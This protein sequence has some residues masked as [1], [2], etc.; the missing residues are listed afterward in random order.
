VPGIAT[1]PAFRCEQLMHYA[2]ANLLQRTVACGLLTAAANRPKR[3]RPRLRPTRSQA[4]RTAPDSNS[5]A[6]RVAGPV[7]MCAWLGTK[8]AKTREP[9]GMRRRARTT[10]VR[11]INTTSRSALGASGAHDASKESVRNARLFAMSEV[12]AGSLPPWSQS[13]TNSSDR[14]LPVGL[15]KSLRRPRQS[16]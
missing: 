1:A 16:A 7:T 13:P 6:V 10:R 2:L 4:E 15:R 5:H 11:L 8:G 14:R 9:W 12:S 3:V